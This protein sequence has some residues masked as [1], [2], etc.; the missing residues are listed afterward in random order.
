MYYVLKRVL[1]RV[2]KIKEIA[3]RDRIAK[4]L[5]KKM[6]IENIRSTK[7]ISIKTEG[8]HRKTST[9]RIRKGRENTKMQVGEKKSLVN[10]ESVISVNL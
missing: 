8:H 1:K 4:M 10:N 5:V 6:H 7:R 2:Q 9:K 3:R